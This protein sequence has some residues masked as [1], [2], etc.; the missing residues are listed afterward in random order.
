[1]NTKRIASLITGIVASGVAVTALADNN[2]C[3]ATACQ[4]FEGSIH[5]TEQGSI[6]NQGTTEAGVVCPIDRGSFGATQKLQAAAF[7]SSNGPNLVACQAV[8]NNA[9]SGSGFATNFS[10]NTGNGSHEGLSFATIGHS[11]TFDVDYMVCFLDPGGTLYGYRGI[12]E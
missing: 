9:L 8:T 4:V 1:M 5:Y 7:V 12:E 10:L 3:A 2:F 11:G 6:A